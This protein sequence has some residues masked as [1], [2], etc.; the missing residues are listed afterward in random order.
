[1]I[2]S[3]ER[4]RA[5]DGRKDIRKSLGGRIA[6]KLR[7]PSQTLSISQKRVTVTDVVGKVDWAF[8]KDKGSVDGW[9]KKDFHFGK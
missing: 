2:W 9:D 4:W 1:M 8:S 6:S 7:A 5:Y 3:L